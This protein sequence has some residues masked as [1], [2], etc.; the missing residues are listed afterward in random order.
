MKKWRQTCLYKKVKYEKARKIL[1]SKLLPA[2]RIAEI[3][4]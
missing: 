4:T 1:S 2:L 3:D